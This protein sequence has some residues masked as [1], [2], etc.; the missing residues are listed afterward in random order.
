MQNWPLS[1][2]ALATLGSFC[3]VAQEPPQKQS[4]RQNSAIAARLS[5]RA[6]A[7]TGRISDDGQFLIADP[8]QNVWTIINPD[9]T[10]SFAA[11]RIAILAQTSPE[12]NEVRV[13]TAKPEKVQL[14]AIARWSDSAF[15][16]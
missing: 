3:A 13:L 2:I 1:L 12:K 16:R 6:V 14:P 9:T 15:R 8:D 10:K 5:K 11:Q 7:L 4:V